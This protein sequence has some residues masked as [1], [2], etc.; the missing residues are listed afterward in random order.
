M[1]PQKS[2]SENYLVKFLYSFVLNINTI[3]SLKYTKP[4]RDS[5]WIICVI[6]KNTYNLNF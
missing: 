1:A 3:D 2:S 4:H 5:F 6:L